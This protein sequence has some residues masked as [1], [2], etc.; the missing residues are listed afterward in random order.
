MAR[1]KKQDMSRATDV[2]ESSRAKARNPEAVSPAFPRGLS[3]PLR[4][5]RDDRFSLAFPLSDLI[6]ARS[7][8]SSFPSATWERGGYGAKERLIVFVT[9]SFLVRL[10]FRISG[11]ELRNLGF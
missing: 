4:F 2:F 9:R 10:L 3:T 1:F 7:L 8:L 6:F 5:A 11:F